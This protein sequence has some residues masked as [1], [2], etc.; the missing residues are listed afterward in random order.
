MDATQLLIAALATWQAVEVWHHSL[1]FAGARA[2]L[3]LEDGFFV[4]LLLCPFCLSVW[5]ALLCCGVVWAGWPP[6][7]PLGLLVCSFL[8][9]AKLFVYTLA[10]SRLA[11][12]GNDFFHARCRT[13]R[14]DEVTK[15]DLE[16]EYQRE[17]EPGDAATTTADLRPEAGG[18]GEEV[19]ER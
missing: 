16:H 4:Q 17:P 3:E 1:L 2:S 5:V 9:M 8:G 6:P 14:G 10:A 7:T 19:S 18:G 11:N 12:L 13:P 15:L